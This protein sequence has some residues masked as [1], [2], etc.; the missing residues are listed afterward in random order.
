MQHAGDA[1]IPFDLI[2]GIKPILP[3]LSEE[4]LCRRLR[5]SSRDTLLASA[6]PGRP[7]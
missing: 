5:L 2:D 4:R 1:L 3:L 7:A 6:M